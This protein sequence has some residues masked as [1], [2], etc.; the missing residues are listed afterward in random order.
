MPSRLLLAK[1]DDLPT[2][3]QFIPLLRALG[4]SPSPIRQIRLVIDAQIVVSVLSFH[5]RRE[6][7]GART[8]LEEVI[9]SGTVI[10]YAPDWIET[11]ISKHLPDIADKWE[12]SVGELAAA[13]D[14]FRAHLRLCPE[15]DLIPL[16][17]KD[18]Y[19]RLRVIDPNDL[20][21][22]LTRE[23]VGAVA[24]L[25]KDRD[26]RKAGTPVVTSEIIVDLREYARSKAVELRIRAGGT[27]LMTAAAGTLLG[28][29][30]ALVGAARLIARAP[31]VIQILLAVGA[32]A[33]LI[34]PKS[35]AT[36]GNGLKNFGSSLLDSWETTMAPTILE[37]VEEHA[38][39][40][41]KADESWERAKARLPERRGRLL[42]RDVAYGAV[43]GAGVPLTLGQVQAGTLAHG[44]KPKGRDF[45]P[46]LQTV[47]RRDKR[48]ER[49][50]NGRWSVR[51]SVPP[52][53]LDPGNAL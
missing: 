16:D 49:D 12:V 40:R 13:W 53:V 19:A 6:K 10:A 24:V 9:L 34:H 31:M 2:F 47:L 1:S 26:F 33:L 43:L 17:G 50:S 51:T 3:S 30:A 46:Y 23:K 8:D 42:L 14:G 32:L 15:S 35:R 45:A 22:A 7:P 28:S 48:L 21:Y 29:G 25:T 5:A 36:I 20:P 52:Q 38:T 37:L 11:E 27:V 44:Y 4:A 18:E 39:A 41:R